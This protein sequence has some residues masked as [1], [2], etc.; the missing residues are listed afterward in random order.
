M[1]YVIVHF[2]LDQCSSERIEH[3]VCCVYFT[4]LSQ[5]PALVRQ[6]WSNAETRTA[7]IV[8]C[9]TAAYVSPQLCNQ[10][11]TDVAQHETKFKN[12]VVSSFFP[13][14]NLNHCMSTTIREQG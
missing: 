14:F 6:W 13:D 12:M 9:V 2:I 3:M 4:A 5:L 11:L 1:L 7:Q 10:E 8:E